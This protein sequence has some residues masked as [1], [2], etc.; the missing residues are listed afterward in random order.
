MELNDDREISLDKARRFSFPLSAKVEKPEHFVAVI[1]TLAQTQS[2]RQ[3]LAGLMDFNG[4]LGT[5]YGPFSVTRGDF[6]L[7]WEG[8]SEINSDLL[9]SGN[10]I[11]PKKSIRLETFFGQSKPI[12]HFRLGEE[13]GVLAAELIFAAETEMESGIASALSPIKTSGKSKSVHDFDHQQETLVKT[14]HAK[15]QGT[16]VKFALEG[17]AR[18][19]HRLLNLISEARLNYQSKRVIDV[20]AQAHRYAA[21]FVLELAESQGDTTNV[22]SYYARL[23]REGILRGVLTQPSREELAQIYK[24]PLDQKVPEATSSGNWNL[25]LNVLQN[26]H[27]NPHEV[28]QV[29]EEEETEEEAKED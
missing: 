12:I 1:H 27:S 2:G 17:V 18:E 19:M 14:F 28:S 16:R 15:M 3:L 25:C 9:L 22:R 23:Q 7:H 5:N 21:E 6:A 24:M 4:S 13:V 29:Q 11:R 8:H 26:Y 10:A 20:L